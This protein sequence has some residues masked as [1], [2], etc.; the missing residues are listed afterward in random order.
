VNLGQNVN[1][2]SYDSGPSISA[3]GLSLF[4]GSSRPGG[5]GGRDIWLTRR[6][7]LSDPFGPTVNLGPTVNSSSQDIT[8]F[9][10]ADGSTLYF[11]SN[12]PGGMGGHDLWHVSIEPIIDL[13][14]DGTVDSGDMRV[15]VNHWGEDDPLCDIGPTPF[16]DGIVDV[17]DLIVLAEHL[18]EDVND[19]TLLAHWALDETEGST[20]RDSVSGNDDLVMGGAIWQP[21]GGVVGGALE[22]DG[23]D[24]HVITTIGLNPSAGPFSIF[25]WIKGGAPG[26]VVISEPMGT[27]WLV[28]DAEGKLMTEL[29]SAGRDATA[30]LSQTVIIDGAWHRIGLVW[31]GS[32]RMLCVDGVT[33]AEDTQN[34]LEAYASGLYF[35]VGND[36][37]PSS[38]L[39]GLIDDIRIYSR[40]VKP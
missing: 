10:S 7:T 20:A 2:S 29:T 16:G 28:A 18:F 22:L 27:D 30:L 19:P 21:T 37:L 25:A 40:A 26:Q 15:M 8:P 17:Q 11:C 38:F 23:V 39:S 34:G 3:D 12:R 9:I 35:G 31:D 14:G 13:N 4:F 32:R 6:K 36:Y 24:D 33:V 1:S 5:Y